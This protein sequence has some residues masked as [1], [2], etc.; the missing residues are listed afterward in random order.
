MAGIFQSFAGVLDWRFFAI[1]FSLIG[2]ALTLPPVYIKPFK[3]VR[4]NVYL[5]IAIAVL[6]S[7][8]TFF[9]EADIYHKWYFAVLLGLMAFNVV[10]CKLRGLPQFVRKLKPPVHQAEL[11]S[12][13]AA[14]ETARLI[15]E[16]AGANNMAVSEEKEAEGTTSFFAIRQPL[17]RWGDFIL[18]VSIV[19]ILAGN[20][21]G[22][23][24]GFEENLPIMEGTTTRMKNRPYEVA[25]KDF[26][27]EYYES[28]GAPSLYA[29]DLEVTKD[30]IVIGAKRIIV[31][32]P[33]DIDRVRFYQASWGMT[34]EFR[35]ARL[36]M[37]GKVIELKAREVVHIPNTPLSIR[38]N[39]FYPTFDIDQNGRATTRDFEGKNPAL[40]IDFLEKEELR[41]RLWLLKNQ[42]DVAF[43]VKDGQVIPAKTPPPFF[44]IDV[45]PILFSGVQ[46][47]Y[48]PGAPIFWF[49]SVILLIGLCLHFYLHERRL[50]FELTP[51]RQG[52]QV[53]LGGWTSRTP[54]EFRRQFTDWT[55]E[56]NNKL[57]GK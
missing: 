46:V 47:G 38:A 55:D 15:K 24:K 25:L 32:E 8:G 26:D 45:D 39:A 34:D 42:P 18:H 56:I 44:L 33:L 37:A 36:H 27:I 51:E 43:Q 19:G 23:L 48:D 9:P 22:A 35:S 14:P 54:E 10:V 30:G 20:L 16:W 50:R 4:F 31:N 17:Q 2:L 3:S 52:T 7:L 29:S 21:L 13:H 6:S 57:R 11:K 28:T 53:V 41:V 12:D 5:F 1:F 49:F 40:Q